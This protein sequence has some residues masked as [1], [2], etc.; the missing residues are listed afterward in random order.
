MV[1]EIKQLAR[2]LVDKVYYGG[3]NEQNVEAVIEYSE[4]WL[5]LFDEITDAQ[6]T[7]SGAHMPAF[8]VS[9]CFVRC[10]ELEQESLHKDEIMQASYKKCTEMYNLLTASRLFAKIPPYYISAVRE[11]EYD[12]NAVGWRLTLELTPIEFNGI[13]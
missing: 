2:Q 6:V 12:I 4:E 1:K 9:M 11:L 13:C 3:R 8:K 10:V 7:V 5:C